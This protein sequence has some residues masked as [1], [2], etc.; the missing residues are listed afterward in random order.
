MVGGLGPSEGFGISVMLIDK[1]GDC[2]MESVKATM[3]AAPD[4]ALGDQG[5][6]ALDLINP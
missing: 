1:A 3:D 5:E 4:L 2:G 6:E